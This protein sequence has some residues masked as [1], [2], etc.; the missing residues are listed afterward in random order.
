MKEEFLQFVRATEMPEPT[1][2]PSAHIL[3]KLESDLSDSKG[4]HDLE[5]DS[6]YDPVPFD[7]AKHGMGA[8]GAASLGLLSNGI[9]SGKSVTGDY[10]VS[11]W[12]KGSTSEGYC[13][14]QLQITGEAGYNI[15]IYSNGTLVNV[16]NEF[17]E[18]A[19]PTVDIGSENFVSVI[20]NVVGGT[21]T[22]YIGG[23]AVHTLDFSTNTGQVSNFYSYADADFAFDEIAI[24]NSGLSASDIAYIAGG[25]ELT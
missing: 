18:G 17:T 13:A 12:S 16:D 5:I 4:A 9:F 8:V 10:A 24:F 14:F 1:Q 22:L 3:W 20:L 21:A 15:S 11:L 25:N 2:P 23:V 6:G 7:S 19:T